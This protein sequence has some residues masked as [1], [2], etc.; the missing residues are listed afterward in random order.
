MAHW[1]SKNQK[2]VKWPTEPHPE[3]KGW[4]I[5]DCGCCAGIEWGGE[6]PVECRAC[7]GQGFLCHHIKSGAIALWP[8]GPFAGKRWW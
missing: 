2:I 3:Y 8:G 4:E 7:Q 6:Y 1:D 5:I